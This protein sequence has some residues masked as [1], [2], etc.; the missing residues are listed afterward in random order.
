[1]TDWT[2]KT[3]WLIGAS[4]GLGRALAHKLSKTGAQVVVSARSEERL[5]S[6]IAE[7][8][9]RARYLVADV[10]DSE[11]LS[12]AAEAVG[13]VDGI[14]YLSG[15]LTPVSSRK[16]DSAKIE[17]MIDVN[18]LGAVRAIG[19]VLPS[20]LERGEGHIVLTGSLSAY[21]GLPGFAG[22]GA[23]KAGMVSLAET[24]RADL[25]A[26]GVKV[27]IA[28]PGYIRTRMTESFDLPK[29]MTMSAEDA[30]DRIFDL[31][32]SNRFSSAFP[33]ILSLGARSMQLMPDWLYFLMFGRKS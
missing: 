27:Q 1:M 2:N 18:L 22:Y 11:S 9:G 10:T 31:M 17:H 16:W 28:N 23:S 3:Y 33:G 6:L 32:D 15:V 4:E 30:A 29:R 26:T 7:L 24:M 25:A 12:R 19:A 13:P 14:V 8:P 5:A 20:M 21:G